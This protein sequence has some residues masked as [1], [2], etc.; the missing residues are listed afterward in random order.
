MKF[1]E[2][3]KNAK[4]Y[5]HIKMNNFSGLIKARNVVA[6]IKGKTIPNEK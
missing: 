4:L 6:T 2:D 5:T 3:L 1:K